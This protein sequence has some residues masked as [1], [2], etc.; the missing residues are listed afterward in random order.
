MKK[1]LN[2]ISGLNHAGTEAV[3]MN[4]YRNMD[5]SK[6]QFDFLVLNLGAGYYE[7]EIEQ[8]GGTVFKIPSFRQ[9]PIKNLT[10]RKKFFKKHAREYDVVE[11]HSPSALRYAYCKLA[12]KAGVPKVIFHIHNTAS[13][14]G[15]LVNHARK[16]LKKYCDEI[17]TCSQLAAVSVMGEN[18]DKIVYNAID[19]SVY[20]F[21]KNLRDE[22]RGH[23]HLTEHHKV[24]GQIGRYS[25]VKN[26]SFSLEAFAMAAQE[27]ES[28]ILMLKG[29]GE[30]KE[31]IIAKIHALDLSS[32][33]IMVGDEYEAYALYNAFDLLILPSLY[34]GFPVVLVEA[35]ANGLKALVSNCVS[36]ETNISGYLSFLELN[37]EKWA[38]EFLKQENFKRIPSEF[39][40]NR[41]DYNIVNEA[42]KLQN[43]YLGVLS[44]NQIQ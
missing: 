41:T 5:R 42:K 18:A 31:E 15:F 34:E 29:F 33:V 7:P 11:V 12:K 22:I 26:H 44:E 35:Q 24:I 30:L 14:T 43:E 8:L 4:Y 36:T 2:V 37:S 17:V 19:Y 32:R 20:R 16:Q 27:D 6:I 40:F 39:D 28:L 1:V 3:V 23:F 25:A 13:E 10:A 38:S 21:H 9:S